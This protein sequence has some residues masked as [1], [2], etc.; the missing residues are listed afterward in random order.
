ME[1]KR[2]YEMADSLA[3][4]AKE[5]ET[6]HYASE[7]ERDVA[8][9]KLKQLYEQIKFM[10]VKPLTVDS[11]TAAT[12]K[13]EDSPAQEK[14]DSGVMDFTVTGVED[15][16]ESSDNNEDM[17]TAPPMNIA[18]ETETVS[19]ED[20]SEDTIA[21]RNKALDELN[22]AKEAI[23]DIRR[24]DDVKIEAV[25]DEQAK[26]IVFDSPSFGEG[27][28]EKTAQP[29]RRD[30]TPPHAKSHIDKS[31]LRSLY[32]DENRGPTSTN[33]QNRADEPT[34]SGV[35]RTEPMNTAG[36]PAAEPAKNK[37]A[38]PIHIEPEP[39]QSIKKEES[40]T[41]EQ[42][43]QQTG[44]VSSAR[45][46]TSY[47]PSS[48]IASKMSVQSVKQF[49]GL[50]DKFLLLAELF[51]N[52]SVE[53]ERTIYELDSMTSLDDAM[54]YI[55]DNFAHKQHTDGAKLLVDLMVRKLM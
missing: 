10:R 37:L 45:Q 22:E 54:L 9:D 51:D 40:R 11:G 2:I 29:I 14:A 13:V 39:A 36:K 32:D 5:W 53:Y 26:D 25:E 28:V 19:T 33:T 6:N 4:L 8:L 20:N 31:V 43:S 48:G 34:Q 1:Y 16:R 21:L 3:R 42:I 27:S 49:M 30:S 41:Y 52:N 17:Y 7:L 50:N 55:H 47:T 18:A 15:V 12:P 44:T 35:S 38:A 46:H 23:E 24:I